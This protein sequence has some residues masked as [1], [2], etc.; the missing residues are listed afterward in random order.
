MQGCTSCLTAC[1]SPCLP[2]MPPSYIWIWCCEGKLRFELSP[3][4]WKGWKSACLVYDSS[5]A[6]HDMIARHPSLACTKKYEV[7]ITSSTQYVFHLPPLQTETMD[8]FKFK[9]HFSSVQGLAFAPVLGVFLSRCPNGSCKSPLRCILW[10]ESG[11][12]MVSGGVTNLVSSSARARLPAPLIQ[13]ASPAASLLT[14]LLAHPAVIN[15]SSRWEYSDSGW[16]APCIQI[17][18]LFSQIALQSAN[19]LIGTGTMEAFRC[20]GTPKL[21]P[22]SVW[23]MDSSASALLEVS[24]CIG[25]NILIHAHSK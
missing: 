14:T 5:F 23:G 3:C 19:H 6:A 20:V 18:A 25:G 8:P 10:C 12:Q 16:Q 2:M 21:Q 13:A 22:N 11:P 17:I 24:S 4:S 1:C 7:F 15:D 9:A